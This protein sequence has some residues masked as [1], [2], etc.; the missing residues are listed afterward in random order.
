MGGSP[1][2]PARLE[3]SRCGRREPRAHVHGNSQNP[4]VCSRGRALAVK[5]D[6][7]VWKSWVLWLAGYRPQPVHV[8]RLSRLSPRQTKALHGAESPGVHARLQSTAKPDRTLISESTLS[9]R[10]ATPKPDLNTPQADGHGH[11]RRGSVGHCA[12][13]LR[14]A[15]VRRARAQRRPARSCGQAKSLKIWLGRREVAPPPRLMKYLPFARDRT[16]RLS[17]VVAGSPISTLP[18][19]WPCYARAFAA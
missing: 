16:A 4:A 11:R 18:F 14:G 19:C 12:R 5:R 2:I 13:H 1:G 15:T 9:V 17:S 6:G 3:D 10:W 7:E 8:D